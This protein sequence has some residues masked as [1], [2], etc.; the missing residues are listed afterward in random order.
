VEKTY[1]G[2]SR[3]IGA[4]LASSRVRWL[5]ESEK[6]ER[7]GCE[8]DSPV[9]QDKMFRFVGSWL[10]STQSGDD[11]L[12]NTPDT[13]YIHGSIATAIHAGR[14]PMGQLPKFGGRL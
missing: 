14:R 3:H 8:I 7:H 2:S 6:D 1:T 11:E 9:K 4:R 10:I 5:I 13:H 12:K